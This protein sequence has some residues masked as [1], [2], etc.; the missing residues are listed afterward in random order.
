MP[1]DNKD[2]QKFLTRIS[3]IPFIYNKSKERK[4]KRKNID[5]S[6]FK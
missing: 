3:G 2:V 1:E 5:L 4:K 6:D